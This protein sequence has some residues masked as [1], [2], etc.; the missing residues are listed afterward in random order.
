ML[1]IKVF[2]IGGGE[3]AFTELSELLDVR[4]K[5][6]FVETQSQTKRKSPGMPQTSEQPAAEPPKSPRTCNRKVLLAQSD[7]I[8]KAW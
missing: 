4:S 3:T 7:R 2:V 8:P 6:K 1:S 5:E